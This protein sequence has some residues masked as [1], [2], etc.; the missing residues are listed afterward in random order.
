MSKGKTKPSLLPRR[1][2][3]TRNQNL[4]PN[5]LNIN[6][7]GGIKGFAGGDAGALGFQNGFEG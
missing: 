1:S 3:G 2:M 4:G 7:C 6:G 5:I